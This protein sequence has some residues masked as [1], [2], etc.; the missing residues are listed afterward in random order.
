MTQSADEIRE[1]YQR[2]A[3]ARQRLQEMAVRAVPHAKLVEHAQK[4]GLPVNEE[5]A[6][7]DEGELAYAFDLAI[8]TAPPG[9]T[10]AI[11]R[12]AKQHAS[13]KTE[14]ALV[15]NGLIRSWLS[16]FRVIG[17]H[18]EMG[19]VVEDALFGGEVW[20]MDDILAEL[21]EAEGVFC[22]RLARIWGF[23]ITTGTVA[24]LDAGML[25]AIRGTTAQG[26]VDPSAL[27]EDP[28]FI[29]TMWQRALGFH[30]DGGPRRG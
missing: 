4:L 29:R 21:G 1:F 22:A 19:L 2:A 30:P 5:M 27:I 16:I 12:V 17:P 24:P 10:R 25:T 20:V 18:P 28:R 3:A 8:Y 7:L 9:R 11:D 15:L 23:A 14:A 13:L 26:G 6:Q